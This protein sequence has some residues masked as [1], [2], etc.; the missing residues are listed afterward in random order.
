MLKQ[1]QKKLGKSFL[2]NLWTVRFHQYDWTS[3]QSH[4]EWLLTPLSHWN[5]NFQMSPF[6]RRCLTSSP[7][8]FGKQSFLM[9]SKFLLVFA[10]VQVIHK[11]YVFF[12]LMWVIFPEF[13]FRTID[14]GNV[15]SFSRLCLMKMFQKALIAARSENM[16][17]KVQVS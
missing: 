5:Q 1:K 15:G 16:L 6:W 8:L 12:Y 17:T 2:D 7:W 14:G 3:S 11:W 13:F 9:K 4:N 10:I